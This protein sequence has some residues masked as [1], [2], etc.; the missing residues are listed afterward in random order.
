MIESSPLFPDA[1]RIGVAWS[2][3][4]VDALPTDPWDLPLHA[5][6]TEQDWIT[7]R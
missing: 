6:V 5:I 2:V 1:W 4:Q 3:Q 7:L